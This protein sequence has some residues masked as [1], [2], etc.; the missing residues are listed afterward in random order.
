MEGVQPAEGDSV[1]QTLREELAHYRDLFRAQPRLVQRFVEAQGRLLAEAL[2]RRLPQ[3]RFTLPDRVVADPAA[4]E[5]A[6]PSPVPPEAREQ[7]VGG[8]IDRLAR[9]DLRAG[10]RSRLTELEQSEDPALIA[11]AG[12]VRH[13]TAM[14]MLHGMLPAGRTVRYAVAEGDTIASIPLES[15]TQPASALTAASDA[16][17]EESPAEAGRGELLVPY[18]PAARRFFLPQW[19]AFNEDGSLLVKSVQEAE[20]HM[21]SMQHFLSVLHAALG[22]A[23]YLVAD[24]EFRRKRYGMLGQL[25]NQGRALARHET[26][27]IIRTIRRRAEAQELNRGLSLRLPYFDDQDLDLRTYPFEVIPAGRIPF[28]PAF[29]VRAVRE[30]AGKI[31]Q[32]TRLAPSTRRHLLG[33]LAELERAFDTSRGGAVPV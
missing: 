31:A 15:E 5:G 18:V 26:G 13:A 8:V 9:A 32:D 29:V 10:L 24:E 7:L 4:G 6:E 27:E 22:L 25:V 33:E 17:A 20:A 2:E 21:R 23:P 28:I 30:E 12:L 16:V 1:S 3:A 19:V 14:H 11:A